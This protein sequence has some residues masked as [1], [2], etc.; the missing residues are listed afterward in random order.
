MAEAAL[1]GASADYILAGGP[2]SDYWFG[3]GA[4]GVV[5]RELFTDDSSG[6]AHKGGGA[7]VNIGGGLHRGKW[8]LDGYIHYFPG[9]HITALQSMLTYDVD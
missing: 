8:G 1:V 3:A 6:G 9:K 7:G 2:C 4:S 5:Y